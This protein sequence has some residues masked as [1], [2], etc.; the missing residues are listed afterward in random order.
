MHVCFS[1]TWLLLLCRRGVIN[2][3]VNKG[4]PSGPVIHCYSAVG[5]SKAVLSLFATEELLFTGSKGKLSVFCIMHSD[6]QTMI[7]CSIT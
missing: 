3:V 5:H 2:P 1:G 6:I 4:T 7:S